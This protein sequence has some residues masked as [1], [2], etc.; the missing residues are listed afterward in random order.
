MF[1]DSLYKTIT[2]RECWGASG[3]PTLPLDAGTCTALPPTLSLRPSGGVQVVRGAVDF[4][5]LK[6]NSN[7][8]HLQV[9]VSKVERSRGPCQRLSASWFVFSAVLVQRRG[10]FPMLS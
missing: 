7:R 8:K 9:Q 10:H 6:Q 5:A 2:V 3:T 1:D 4:L